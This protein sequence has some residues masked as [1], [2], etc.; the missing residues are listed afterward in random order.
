MAIANDSINPTSFENLIVQTFATDSINAFVIKYTINS[1]II[2]LP[3][4][5]SYI[6]DATGT[7]EELDLTNSTSQKS[8]SNCYTAYFCDY[9][10]TH[11]AGE[12]CKNQYPKQVCPAS[13]S[14]GGGAIIIG[15]PG[16]TTS[17]GTGTTATSGTANTSTGSYS[18]GGVPTSTVYPTRTYTSINLELVLSLDNEQA[19]WI[20]D[21]A[22]SKIKQE[23]QMYIFNNVP[24]EA[25]MSAE[26]I[27]ECNFAEELIDYCMANSNVDAN[28]YVKAKIWEVTRINSN[29]LKPCMKTILNDIKRLQNGSVGQIIQKFAGNTPQ[30]NWEVKDGYL[31]SDLYGSTSVRYNT[32]T[33]TITTTFDSSKF[34]DATDLAIA[35]TI[36]HEAVHAYVTTVIWNNLGNATQQQLLLGPNWVN[37]QNNF[38]HDYMVTNY[39]IPIADALQ[40]YGINK[41]YSLTRQFY[42][43][44][45]WGGLTH[46]QQTGSLNSIFTEQVPNSSDRDRI[47][48]A[49]SI[50]VSGMDINEIPRTPKGVDSGCY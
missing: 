35:R 50:E 10:G 43:D 38:G 12:K 49:I 3:E 39:L 8:D 26:S 44:M 23:L 28:K 11:A 40:E 22:N 32:L 48:N 33:G 47:L 19:N 30:F 29:A 9:H 4:H 37:S 25:T 7:L 31:S 46:D 21:D 41:G 45:A 27:A 36:I 18:S 2:Y 5:D 1:D 34:A 17:G 14:S 24:L 6:L 20:N 16:G 13:N 42:E 15:I